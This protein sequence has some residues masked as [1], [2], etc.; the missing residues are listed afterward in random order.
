VAYRLYEC[1]CTSLSLNIIAC[2]KTG[3]IRKVT[4]NEREKP[5]EL[6][7]YRVVPTFL[8]PNASLNNLCAMRLL[9][10]SCIA[11]VRNLHLSYFWS[12]SQP[13]DRLS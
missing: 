13:S 1:N 4:E 6:K 11:D 8:I 5:K 10:H 9:G 7:Y 12:E 3:Q 2:R